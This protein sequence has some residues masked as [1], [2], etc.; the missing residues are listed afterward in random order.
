M[1]TKINGYPSKIV[2]NTLQ[3]VKK[4]IQQVSLMQQNITEIINENSENGAKIEETFP[5]ICLPYK[6]KEGESI[7]KGLKTQLKKSL[8][9]HVKPRFICKG[10]KLGLLFRIKDQIKNEHQ[11]SLVYGYY[12]DPNKV[13]QKIANYVGETNDRYGSRIHEHTET[14]KLSAVFK[15]TQH[16]KIDVSKSNFKV[17]EKR[18]KKTVDRKIDEALYIKELKPKLNE[19]VK[20]FKLQ[21][22]N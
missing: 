8:P 19:Q 2:F 14:D 5:Y 17:L 15:H 7:L 16:N 21:L 13:N 18:F 11:S 22:F 12:D 4:H 1:F 3:S 20:S 9:K 6:Y 10:K